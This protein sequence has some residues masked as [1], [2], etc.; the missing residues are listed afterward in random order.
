MTQH[1]P[2]NQAIQLVQ[3][4]FELENYM[5]Q[6]IDGLHFNIKQPLISLNF[7]YAPII[8]KRMI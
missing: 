7:K 6:E 4:R 5:Q 2:W 8:D 1:E 3:H